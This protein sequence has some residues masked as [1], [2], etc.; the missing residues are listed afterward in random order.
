M[1]EKIRSG[2]PETG[3]TRRQVMATSAWAVPVIAVAVATP[4]AAASDQPVAQYTFAG[5]SATGN[6]GETLVD[7]ARPGARIR[8]VPEGNPVPGQVVTFV[9]VSGPF[10][11]NETTATSDGEGAARVSI[12][13]NA[14][15]S[16]GILGAIQALW[17]GPDGVSYDELVD[18]STNFAE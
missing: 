9:Y 3:I 12:T 13:F 4:L 17:T 14:D 6:P 11:L 2:A 18:V 1:A 15:A 5:I 7:D 10:T 8:T 16:N